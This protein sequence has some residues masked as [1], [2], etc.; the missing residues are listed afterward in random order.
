MKNFIYYLSFLFLLATGCVQ[1]NLEAPKMGMVSFSTINFT[2]F[3]SLSPNARVLEDSEWKHIFK[4][5]ATLTITHKQ[6]GAEYSLQY[7][8]NDFTNAYQIQLPYGEYTVF[9][10]VTGGDFEKFLPFTISGEFTLAETSLDISL[11]GS[12]DYGLV[13]VK[14]EFVLSANLDGEHELEICDQGF[15]LYAY[16]KDGLTPTLTIYENFKGQALQ[17]ELDIAAYNHYHFYLKLTEVQGTVNLIELAIGPFEY[18]EEFFE[19]GGEEE[20]T[21]VTDADGNEYKVVKIG[22]QYW[23]A[24]NLRNTTYCDGTPLETITALKGNFPLGFNQKPDF[25]ISRKDPYTLENNYFYS[26]EV[27][28]SEKNICPCN[29][30]ISSDEDWLELERYIGIPENELLNS[31]RGQEQNAAGQ[32][33]AL[34]WEEIYGDV[35]PKVTVTNSTGFTAYPNGYWYWDFDETGEGIVMIGGTKETRWWTPINNSSLIMYRKLYIQ[36]TYAPSIYRNLESPSS[37]AVYS[38]RCVKD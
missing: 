25:V 20:I 30:H 24:E 16:V 3:G 38:I 19:I 31:I 14:K 13:T 17:K 2:H 7:N 27:A 35:D 9:S 37:D 28:K 22:E 29:W 6:T 4:E 15:T 18:H 10:E 34:D 26:Y 5:S 12:T 33:M 21:S 1:E 23:M 11:Q 32:L 8:P 36:Y